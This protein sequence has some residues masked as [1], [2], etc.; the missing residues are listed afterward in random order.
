MHQT[1]IDKFLAIPNKFCIFAPMETKNENIYLSDEDIYKGLRDGDEYVLNALFESEQFKSV[2]GIIRSKIFPN[3]EINSVKAQAFNGL[4]ELF[5]TKP[6]LLHEYEEEGGNILIWLARTYIKY[7]QEIRRNE[8]KAQKRHWELLEKRMEE[9][10]SIFDQREEVIID[11]EN[12][13]EKKE[14]N[15]RI[16]KAINMMENS[17]YADI[18]RKELLKDDS[19]ILLDSS[20]YSQDRKR[21]Y[22]A[23]YKIYFTLRKKYE[24]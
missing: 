4:Y 9:K 17:Y 20:N 1:F 13:L 2:A 24:I 19:I 14:S 7:F 22:K 10:G 6:E 15:E 21:A 16:I 11:P 12:D 23:L 5:K 3:R 18:M 8:I